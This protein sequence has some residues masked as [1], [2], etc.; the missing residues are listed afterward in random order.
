M[1][2]LKSLK[3]VKVLDSSKLKSVIGGISEGPSGK[4]TQST[5]VQS[6]CDGVY[7]DQS[8]ALR[9]DNYIG[10]NW[11]FGPWCPYKTNS[12]GDFQ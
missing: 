11:V 9:T 4:M 7:E 6:T 1:K 3:G 8:G 12:M 10:G 5:N 2:T